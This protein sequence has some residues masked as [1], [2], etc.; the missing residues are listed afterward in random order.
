MIKVI[1]CNICTIYYTSEYRLDSENEIL[2]IFRYKR[3]M[4]FM[5]IYLTDSACWKID[6]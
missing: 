2:G 6:L 4:F 3:C 1:N 5:S